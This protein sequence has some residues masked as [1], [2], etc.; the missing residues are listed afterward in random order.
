MEDLVCWRCGA[1]LTAEPLPLSRR[2]VCKACNAELHVCRLCQ[3]YHPRVSDQCTEDRA[4]QVREK[5]RAN[6]CDYFKPKPNA[7]VAQSDTKAE[8]AKARL[9]GLFGEDQQPQR[10][11][12][13]SDPTRDRLDRL[14]DS[15]GEEDT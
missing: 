6:F 2:A 12:T 3:F 15:G 14:F 11:D 13:V 1:T 7:Y 4:E 9:S 5:D 8:A 10:T